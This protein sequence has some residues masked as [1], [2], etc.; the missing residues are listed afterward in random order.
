MKR[1][2]LYIVTWIHNDWPDSFATPNFAQ[3]TA[4]FKVYHRAGAHVFWHEVHITA[5]AIVP[6]AGLPRPQ[7]MPIPDPRM[8]EAADGPDDYENNLGHVRVR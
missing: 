7:V 6:V 8:A 2:M 4:L 3:A 1:K 5:H